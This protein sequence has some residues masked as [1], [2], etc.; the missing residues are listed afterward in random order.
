MSGRTIRRFGNLDALSRAAADELMVIAREA[1]A[2]RG[3]C[4]VGMSG[5]S[6]PKRMNQL[7]A[8]AGR[9]A[10]PWDRIELW[11]GDERTVAADHAD[12]NYRMTRETLIDPLGLS[13]ERIH[14]IDGL[15]DHA[16]AAQA[17]ER[18][19]TGK[20]G[21]PPVLDLV[22]L[23]MG[24]D[25]HTAS[26]FP[27][28]PGLTAPGWVVANQLAVTNLPGATVRITLTAKAINAARKIRFLV[29]GADKATSLAG[30]LEGPA[31]PQRYPSQLIAPTTGEL[32]WMVDDAAAANLR[33]AS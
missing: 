30:V 33:S 28:T 23:G 1:V 32:V 8:A 22:L 7:L 11:W 24:P 15:G 27:H 10:L 17:Y 12:S 4:H 29:G 13:P 14:R 3:V 21:T 2:A 19:L 18:E 5:G 20:L 16:A 26:L 31:D 9:D 6:T 25:G